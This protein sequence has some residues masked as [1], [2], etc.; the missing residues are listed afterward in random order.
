MLYVP[1]R[2]AHWGVALDDECMTY[3]I[4]FRAPNFQDLASEFAN[5]MCDNRSPDDFYTD[6]SS[7][8]SQSGDA[9]RVQDE[10]VQRMWSDVANTML[11][12]SADS[13]T[14]APAPEH[15]R[16]WLGGVLTQKLQRSSG[17]DAHARS[18]EAAEAVAILSDL[19]QG[20]EV[21]L[22]RNEASKLAWMPLASGV[23]VFADGKMWE[24]PCSAGDD[25][26]AGAAVLCGSH[27]LPAHALTPLLRS[28]LRGIVC[29]W[30]EQG[31]LYCPA[32]EED[33][34]GPDMEA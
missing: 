32:D 5:F 15:F 25:L 29:D 4:G 18:C 19:E 12:F 33:E 3:S 9:G 17:V 23:G 10:A 27:I 7:F 14:D 6:P 1:P 2:F 13:V 28:P 30:L 24:L 31:I 26:H 20:V 34:D 16:R 11:G 21:C 22:M 8:A